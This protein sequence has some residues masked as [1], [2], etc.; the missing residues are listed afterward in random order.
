MIAS[1]ERAAS[2]LGRGVAAALGA[3]VGALGI[4]PSF[5]L[6]YASDI[7]PIFD[8]Y[9]VAC[10]ACFDAPCQLDLTQ[11]DGVFRG[12]SK[13]PVYDGARIKAVRPSRLGIDAQSVD[14]WRERGFFPVLRGLMR[15]AMRID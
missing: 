3:L 1:Y 9:C 6:D 15:K 10:H 2:S 13:A 4:T 12:A 7:Q 11:A 5:A 8:R 14:Q